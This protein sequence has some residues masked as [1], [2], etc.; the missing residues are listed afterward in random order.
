MELLQ[1]ASPQL[2][3]YSHWV[4][5]EGIREAYDRGHEEIICLLL[6]CAESI[7]GD[8]FNKLLSWSIDDSPL[9]TREGLRQLLVGQWAELLGQSWNEYHVQSVL[10]QGTDPD[11]RTILPMIKA[12]LLKKTDVARLLL[13]RG[14]NVNAQ[15]DGDTVLLQV[16]TR[17]EWE[18]TWDS[19]SNR[20]SSAHKLR[21]DSPYTNVKLNTRSEYASSP[22]KCDMEFATETDIIDL[23]IPQGADA[24][25]PGRFQQLAYMYTS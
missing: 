9:P 7:N 3:R 17:C 6:S 15:Q 20:S 23:L 18:R 4:K 14:I 25:I 11:L 2:E 24:N 8:L 22:G 19:E 5:N 1:W 10:D 21:S 12:A 13:N 16:V